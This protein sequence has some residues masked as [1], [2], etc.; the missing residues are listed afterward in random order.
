MKTLIHGFIAFAT[1]TMLLSC[2]MPHQ[3]SSLY[4]P[5]QTLFVSNQDG[6]REIFVA[7]L[8]GSAQEQLT[9]NDSDDYEA[10]WSPSGDLIAFTSNRLKGN[11]EVFDLMCKRMELKI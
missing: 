10:S 6:D 5:K 9:N 7:N 1:A 8:D 11:T 4:S 2:A 3:S